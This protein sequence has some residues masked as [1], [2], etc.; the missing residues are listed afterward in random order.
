[1]DY[2]KVAQ[3]ILQNVGGKE[4]INEVTHCM[5]RLRFKVKIT[6][7]VNKDKLAR[8]EGVITVVESMGQIQV[9]IGN[10]VKKVYDEIV[11]M[12]PQSS[13]IDN[14]N[15]NEEKQGIM[16]SILSAVAGIFTP[17]IPAIAGV[18]M[19]KGILSVLAMYYMNKNGVDIKETQSYIIL[20]A[21]ADSIFYFMPIILGYTAAKV[22][23]A[24]KIISMVLG[25]TL[26]YPAFTALMAGEETVRFLG[27]AVTKATYTSSVIPIII[28]IWA[29]SYVEKILE[30]YIPEVIKIIMVP[31]LSLVIIL[32]ATLFLFGPIGIYIG[33]VINFVYKYIYELSP[34]LCGAFIGGL[35][36][37][38]VIFGAHRALL[39]IGISDVAQTGRQNLLAFAGAANFSQAGA[40][41]GVFFKTKNQGLKTISMSATIT[42]LFGITEP[43][44]YG[45]NL[46]LKKP[47]VCAVI[48]GAIG[49][50]IMG[51]GGSYGNAFANQ[52]VLTIPVYAEAGTLGFLSYLGGCAIAFFGSAILTY[53]VGFED[54]EESSKGNSSTIKVETKEGIVDI[55][56]PV[57]GDCIELS[58]VK[59]D[60]FASK[61]MGEGIAVLPTKGVIIAPTDCEVASLFPTLHAIGLKLDN[62]AEMLI[63]VGIN[64]VE[65]NGKHF[66]KHV[67]QGD[68]VKK[69]SKLI[70]FDIDEIKKAGYDVTTPVIVNNTFDFAQVIS[71]KSSHVSTNDKIISLVNN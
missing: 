68:L 36:C 7:K 31:T 54:L 56:S 45:A 65:L 15:G 25:A 27:L 48:C 35:W 10:K 30:K 17:T 61:A 59:D 60:V 49:G 47:M 63:H 38:L 1:M 33:N 29:L 50:G 55:T 28:A 40:A 67:N 62:G 39:P 46:R 42:A 71:C 43:A 34:A 6:S 9:V 66:V 22:F 16:N 57:E 19:I 18:G 44:I 13:E 2:K 4:N 53:L 69:G 32:P 8:T 26:C 5:T 24:N 70:T 23:N 3:E 20:N 52:G 11:K 58:E 12:V 37:V 64:T 21:M 51:M 41:L 14:K